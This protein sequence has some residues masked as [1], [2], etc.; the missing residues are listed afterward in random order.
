MSWQ[1]QRWTTGCATFQLT[2]P[3]AKLVK[4]RVLCGSRKKVSSVIGQ[5]KRK[6]LSIHNGRNTLN[7]WRSSCLRTP[8]GKADLARY[9]GAKPLTLC[10]ECNQLDN[11]WNPLDNCINQIPRKMLVWGSSYFC[12]A[13]RIH[14]LWL[15]EKPCVST[16]RS[17]NT[18]KVSGSAWNTGRGLVTLPPGGNN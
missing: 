17:R 10:V 1:E 5:T 11:Y 13:H 15:I 12:M 16:K 2:L 14:K 3:G 6:R 7:M 9:A 8:N 4:W 18:G